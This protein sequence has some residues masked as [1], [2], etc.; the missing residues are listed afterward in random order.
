[1]A[2]ET[3][4][5]WRRLEPDQRRSQILACARRLFGER[6]YAEVSTSDI[7]REAGVARGLINHYFG[8]KRDLYLAVVRQIMIIPP[9]AVDDLPAEPL[10]ERISVSLDRFLDAV[11]RNRSMWLTT[12]G[13]HGTGRDPDIDQIVS[14]SEEITT[15][16][17]LTVLQLEDAAENREDLRAV[18][19]S[20]GALARAAT[21]EWLGRGRLTREQTK[22]LLAQSL[23]TIRNGV[24]PHLITTPSAKAD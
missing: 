11:S 17:V 15:D 14:E 6:P 21:R 22:L 20:F 12:I 13:L 2:T 16:R 7:A 9:F 5:R 8:T 23:L 19:R 18:I 3:A 24:V 1:M 10:H 4:P